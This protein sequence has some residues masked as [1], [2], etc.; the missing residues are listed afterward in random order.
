MDAQKC[1]V[2]NRNNLDRANRAIH[3]KQRTTHRTKKG[4][5]NKGSILPSYVICT[6]VICQLARRVGMVHM[7]HTMICHLE[8]QRL[9]DDGT[10]NMAASA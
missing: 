4:R 6:L 9:S 7:C 8:S 2:L 1:G 10:P 5:T 3:A